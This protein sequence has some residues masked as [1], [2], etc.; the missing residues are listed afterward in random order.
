LSKDPKNFTKSFLESLPHPQRGI[1][2]TF[3]DSN[4]KGLSLRVTSNTKSF[5]VI[6]KVRGKAEKIFLGTFPDLTVE[7]ARKLA[8]AKLGQIA[9]GINPLEEKRRI[10]A[11]I[12]LGELYQQYMDR[13]S[14]IHKKSWRYDEREIPRFLSKWFKRKISD[15]DRTEFQRLHEAVFL[16]NGR[17]QANRLLERTRALYNKAIEWGWNGNNPT[18]GIK[19]YKEKSRDR[20]IQPDEMPFIIRAIK[21]EENKTVRDFFWIL[22]MT[23][24]RKTN[25]LMMRWDEINIESCVW[26]IPDS[27]N[28]DPIIVGLSPK[29][30]TILKERYSGSNG[31]WVF[32][33]EEDLEKHIVNVKR[34]WQR[35]KE[36]ASIYSW[37]DNDM[38][39]HWLQ[40]IMRE[41]PFY[42]NCGTGFK[43]IVKH[44]V[45]EKITLPP[46][47]MDIRLH[48][49]R[50]TFGSYQ[51][52]TGAS[53]QIIGKS[54]GHKSMQA[55]QIYARL[56]LA[57]IRS[58]TEKAIEAM[59]SAA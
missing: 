21:E 42:Y 55:T 5:Y 44:A 53:L 48:D 51:A 11:E 8:S 25:T 49:I 6:K 32:P 1:R 58:S 33:Q 15:I 29:V 40:A 18:L 23:G 37:L 10:R 34:G 52:M 59:F 26:R 16:Q 13:Y 36:K 19:K 56:N 27:K 9:I 45:T 17:Y 47:L 7:N 54:L 28:G 46:D 41:L 14:K 39:S 3:R 12:T 38:V 20:F 22:L 50:R 43:E 31:K 30:I 24:M 4:I 35:I 2:L 57:P